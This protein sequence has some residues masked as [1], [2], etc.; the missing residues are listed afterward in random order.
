MAAGENQAK[1]I[2]FDALIVERRSSARLIIEL[3]ADRRLRRVETNATPHRI[4]SLETAGRDEPRAWIGR[5]A[6]FGPTFQRGAKCVVQRVLSKVKIAQQSDQ[7][8]EDSAGLRGINGVQSL[9]YLFV[10]IRRHCDKT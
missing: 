8:R 1:P 2:V 9:T 6:L 5:H 3:F 4:N 10:D 7:G